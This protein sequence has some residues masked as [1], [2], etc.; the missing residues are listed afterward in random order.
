MLIE[1]D[2]N[3]AVELALHLKDQQ[4]EA[5]SNGDDYIPILP[6]FQVYRT[7]LTH[8]SKPTQISTDVIGVKAAPQDV[9]LLGEFFTRL[10][11]ETS[12]DQRDGT[13]LPKGAVNLLGPQMY[14]QVLQANNFFLNNVA[15]V[16]VNLE[17][18]GWF[19][20]IDPIET[21]DTAVVSLYDHL[22]RQ[23][24][25]LRIESV[26]Q[27]KC[28]LVTTKSNLPAAR[29]WIDEHLEPMVRKSIPPE[30]NPPAS[31]LPRRLDKP[32][33]TKTTH[34]YADILK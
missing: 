25:F 3:T 10:A 32:V 13:F 26:N 15:T 34:T 7:R 4:L 19:A 21:S 24:W 33:Y 17:Y 18:G 23:P 27:S 29:A 22:T 8:G 6:P 16:P 11:A 1:M 20:V 12:T 9:K 14:A 2:A 30:I 31:Q 5:M 28:L